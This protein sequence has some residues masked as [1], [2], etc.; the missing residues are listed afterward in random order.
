MRYPTVSVKKKKNVYTFMKVSPD[1]KFLKLPPE[2]ELE[3]RETFTVDPIVTFE[4]LAMSMYYLIR[5]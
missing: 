5:I 4:F 2:M 3:G 1:E